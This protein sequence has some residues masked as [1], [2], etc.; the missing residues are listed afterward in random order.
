MELMHEV[1]IASAVVPHCRSH[2]K[3][4]DPHLKQKHLTM[5]A[6]LEMMA[7]QLHPLVEQGASC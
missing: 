6:A 5:V 7:Q 4:G 3:S 1:L 2:Y